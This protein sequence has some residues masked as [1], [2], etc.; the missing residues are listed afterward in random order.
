MAKYR[1]NEREVHIQEHIIEADS[2]EEAHTKFTEEHGDCGCPDYASLVF[3]HSL[4]IDIDRD[5]EE[6]HETTT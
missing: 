1:V 5:I 4:E 2:K 6:I 3:K